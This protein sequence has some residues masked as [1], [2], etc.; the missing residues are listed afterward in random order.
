MFLVHSPERE[1]PGNPNSPRET[2]PKICGGETPA[3]LKAGLAL[4]GQVINR[5][6]PVSHHPRRRTTKLLE[7]IS[8]RG[9]YR[10]RE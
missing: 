8:P 3:C 5:V 7:N 1:D 2:I 10:A 4:Y 6:V 9:Q